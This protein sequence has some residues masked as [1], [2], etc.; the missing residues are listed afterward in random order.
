MIGWIDLKLMFTFVLVLRAE[1][2]LVQVE[3]APKGRHYGNIVVD[4][5]VCCFI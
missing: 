5:R 2:V 3:I 1:E 4:I